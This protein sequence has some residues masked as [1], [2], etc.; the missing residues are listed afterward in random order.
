MQVLK[1]IYTFSITDDNNIFA[2][3]EREIFGF[4]PQLSWTHTKVEISR[5]F[6]SRDTRRRQIMSTCIYIIISEAIMI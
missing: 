3:K 6:L 4:L 1:I 2:T 5:S